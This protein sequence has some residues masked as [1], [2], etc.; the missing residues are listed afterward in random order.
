MVK[1]STQDGLTGLPNRGK[2]ELLLAGA[3][4]RAAREVTP[5]AVLFCDLDGFKAVNDQLGHSAGDDLLKLVAQRL[6]HTLRLHD[7]LGRIGGDEFVVITEEVTD[8]ETARQVADRLI[9][10]VS[11]PITID[12]TAVNVGMTV[13]FTMATGREDAKDLIA[14]AD[15]AMY[16]AKRAGKG[17]S[18]SLSQ[19]IE[20]ARRADTATG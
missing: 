4:R 2:L 1:R 6:T 12:G 16:A 7:V 5:I 19:V 14:E 9:A 8:E 18:M 3:L 17:R 13:G 15:R 11:E 10:A 20:A